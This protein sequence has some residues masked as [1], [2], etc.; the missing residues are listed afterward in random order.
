MLIIMKW[1]NKSKKVK[2][3]VMKTYRK[4]LKNKCLLPKV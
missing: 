4:R 3:W 1:N 2:M